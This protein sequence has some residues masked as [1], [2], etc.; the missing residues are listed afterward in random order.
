M[1]NILTT[2]VFLISTA[3]VHGQIVESSTT[4][5]GLEAKRSFSFTSEAMVRDTFSI[6]VIDP[7][8]NRQAMPV[9]ERSMAARSK[10]DFSFKT[11]YWRSGLYTVIAE[12]RNG[13]RSTHKFRIK[14]KN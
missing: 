7:H 3:S 6:T 11:R 9:Q 2:A 10:I 5:R 4:A 14:N 13:I 12:S 1:K 8:G